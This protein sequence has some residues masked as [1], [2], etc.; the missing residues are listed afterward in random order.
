MKEAGKG[1]IVHNA[2]SKF[3][4]HYFALFTTYIVTRESVV[5]GVTTAVTKPVISL[6]SVAPLHT[7][8]KEGDNSDGFL[9]MSEEAEVEESVEFTAQAHFDHITD[10]LMNFYDIEDPENWITNQ[11]ADSASVNL[12]LAKLLGVAHI[13]CENHLLN[14]EV[15]LWLKN[16]TAHD[17]DILG[18]MRNFGPGTVCKIIHNTMLDLKTNKNRALL[19]QTTDLSPTIGNKTRWGSSHNMLYK[20]HAIEADCKLASANDGA[21]IAMPPPSHAFKREAKNTSTMLS[22]INDVAVLLQERLLPLH[23]SREL[24]EVLILTAEEGRSNA[25]SPWYR[26]TFGKVYISPDSTK[27]PDR[28]FANA[29]CKMQKRQAHTLSVDEKLAINKWLEKPAGN[30]VQSNLSLADCLSQLRG[31]KK[32]KADQMNNACDNDDNCFDHI[33]GSAAEVERLWSI[34]RYILTTSRTK[35]APIVFEAILFLRMNRALWDERTVME[36]LVAVRADQ[37]DEHLKKKLELANEQEENEE[38]GGKDSVGN[39]NEE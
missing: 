29:V 16:S 24:N 37:K 5:D 10:I 32:R 33:I 25:I 11:T 22:D 36:A 15:K 7:P 6:L 39:D 19:W 38:G 20:W 23:R 12:K 8:V 17:D 1:A 2:W 30:E 3:G 13:N 18:M 14:N 28:T 26:N 4:A 27:R 35:M 34:A 21:T 31:G 9:P